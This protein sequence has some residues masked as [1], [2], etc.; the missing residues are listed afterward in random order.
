VTVAADLITTR[1]AL[2]ALLDA[3]R[4]A[5]EASGRVP[6]HV[7]HAAERRLEDAVEAGWR[8]LGL[9]TCANCGA[10]IDS[11]SDLC[12]RPECLASVPELPDAPDTLKDATEGRR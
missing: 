7:T 6:S 4:G 10:P 11:D 8:A 5:A 9:S 3:L 12:D 1:A 2:R